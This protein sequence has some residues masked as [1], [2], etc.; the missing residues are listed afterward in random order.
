MI[1]LKIDQAA[2]S[3]GEP[4]ESAEIGV[5]NT[6]RIGATKFVRQL[7]KHNLIRRRVFRLRIESL[8]NIVRNGDHDFFAR[9]AR[10]V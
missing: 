3:S 5:I 7:L 6:R 9:Q 4:R 1:G 8:E 10:G 2:W